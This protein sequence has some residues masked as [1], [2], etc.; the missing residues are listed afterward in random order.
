MRIP[1]LSNPAKKRFEKKRDVLY[2]LTEIQEG[3]VRNER[4]SKMV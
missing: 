3:E 2:T 1:D 4:Q